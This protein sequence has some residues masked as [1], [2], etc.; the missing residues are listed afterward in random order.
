MLIGYAR[1]STDDQTLDLQLDA[2]R[3][4]GCERILSDE[5]SST[6]VSRPGLNQA[7]EQLRENDILVVWKLDR[8]GRSVKALIE[9]VTG[10]EQRK[11][12]FQSLTDQI[13]TSTPVGRFS[14]TS[15]LHWH[16]WS[17]N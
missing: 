15:W 12:Q 6:K 3:K 4:A 16:K 8:L 14:F 10:L 17:V 13:D 7:L 2:L 11:I 9:M 5:V 1:V